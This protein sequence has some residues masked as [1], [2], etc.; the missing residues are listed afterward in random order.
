MGKTPVIKINGIR[1][2]PGKLTFGAYRQIMLLA[3]E[4]GDM[5]QEECEEDMLSVLRVTFGL[6]R[7]QADQ[8]D[9]RDVLVKYREVSRWAIGAFTEKARA[10]PNG[11]GPDEADPTG[12]N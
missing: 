6:T 5:S 3:D 2:K 7:E 1:Y 11:D 12:R 8:I 4:I 9:A 10:L